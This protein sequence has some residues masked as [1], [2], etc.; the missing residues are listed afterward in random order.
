M[1]AYILVDI[2]VHNMEKYREYLNQITPTVFACGGRY[3]ARGG[4][5]QVISGNW[6]PKR[7][8]IIEFPDLETAQ[9]WVSCEEYAPIHALRNQNASANMI[10]L[11][12]SLDFIGEGT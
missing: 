10:I 5:P 4:T 1:L 8:V 12:G 9:H 11:E 6:Q 3:L 7:L 2:E